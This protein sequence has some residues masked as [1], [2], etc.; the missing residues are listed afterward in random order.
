MDFEEA[1]AKSLIKQMSQGSLPPNGGSI[2]T[3]P[4]C[5]QC[6]LLHPP[7]E[8]GK[9]C[10][11]APIQVGEKKVGTTKFLVDLKNICASQIEK[12]NIK[13]VEKMFKKLTIEITKFLEGYEEEL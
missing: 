8:P 1:K 5:P 10:P 2:A 11:N 9:K 13:D 4:I 7:V 6:G 12:K 3:E